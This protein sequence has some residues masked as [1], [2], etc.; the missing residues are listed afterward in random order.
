[1]SVRDSLL[2]TLKENQNKECFYLGRTITMSG[3]PLFLFIDRMK[4]ILLGWILIGFACSL[5]A[6]EQDDNRVETWLN[7]AVSLPED[8]CRTLHFAKK[9]L[10][11]PYVAGT[12]EVNPHEELVVN[13]DEVDCT[14]FV[15]EVLA[16]AVADKRGERTLKGF[17]NALTQI[18]YRGG[19]L[20]GYTSRLHYFS[21]WIADNE[22]MGVI[23]E[24][25]PSLSDVKQTLH[26]N[27]MSTH[28]DSYRQLKEDSSLVGEMK[29]IEASWQNVEVSYIPKERLAE[30]PEEL[31]IRNG[32]ILAITT[33]IKGLDVVHI[34]FACWIGK[35]LHLLHASSNAMKVILDSQPLFEYSK[36]KKTH[37]GV[38]VLS[39][40]D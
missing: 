25:T 32:D 27:F 38:R 35:R 24:R 2:H 22:R 14:T 8:S 5:M 12:L 21:D 39:F 26:L 7:E 20:D 30:G 16:M 6:C 33:N 23:E 34:G 36:T 10:G 3:C 29:V 4:R 31:G 17:K 19:V 13:L 9:M 11:T 18:R 28:P 37:T 40:V 15:E 1:M